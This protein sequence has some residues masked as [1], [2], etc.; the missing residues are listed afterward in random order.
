MVHSPNSIDLKDND[1]LLSAYMKK[2]EKAKSIRQRWEPLFNECYEYALPM[3]ETF[4]TSARGERRDER[5]FDETAVVGVQEFASRLQS[6]LVPNF[7]RWA[8]FTAGSE[9]PKESRESINNDLDEVTDYVF[10]VIQNSNF[11]Q[12]VHESFM[13]L[14]VGTGVLHVA[15]GDAVNPVKFTALPLPHVVLDVGPDDMVD[16]VFRERDMPFGHIP[17]VYRDMEQMPKL[18]NAIKTNP[19]AEAKVL[20]VV[21]K[22]YSKINEDAYL[23]FVFETTTKCVIKKEQFKGTGSNP[24]ICFRWS[25]DPGAVYGRGPLV[26]ALSA[27]KTTN[28][29]IELVLEN[30]QMAISGVYQMDDDGVIN[31]DTINLVPG[32]VIPKAPNSAGLQPVQAAGSFDVANL[33]LSDMRLNIKRALYNDMLGN[34][35]RTPATA[36]EIAERMADLSRRI[37]SAFGRL[38]AELVQPVLQRVVHILK[39]QNRIKIPVINGRQV[40]VRSVSPLSQAQANADISSVARFLELTQARFGQELTNILI[41]SEQ[42]ATYLAKKFGVPDNLVRD[43]EE[44]KEIIRV[45]QQMQTAM[46]NQQGM[47]PNEQTNQN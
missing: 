33:I 30:A 31:P 23:C 2:Y 9:V 45:A 25:K 34:P 29:T 7:A 22:D 36:T 5:I 11:A 32:T 42:T 38:Q 41:N 6:G 14:A 12:E 24:F 8:D 20:E 28:L 43:L 46:Q 16:H 13:D 1:K 19:D 10:E 21:C 44:R 35:D 4:Y 17:I 37:G 3:R 27:I 15:E 39:K 47:M 26:N 40:K 18:I